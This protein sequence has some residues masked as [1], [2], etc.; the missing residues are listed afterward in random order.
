[1]AVKNSPPNSVERNITLECSP[2]CV[3]NIQ[4]P[5]H[6]QHGSKEHFNRFMNMFQHVWR[7]EESSIF[8]F[9]NITLECS[10]Y[11]VQNI[12][13]PDSEHA[14]SCSAQLQFS[15]SWNSGG[16]LLALCTVTLDHIAHPAT[17]PV[18]KDN[19]KQC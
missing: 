6:A 16:G 10:P 11:C 7:L 8:S 12:Q 9:R 13:C 1:M 15:R 14:L 17:F 2:Y 19:Y 3:Q 5:E 4:C 18:H